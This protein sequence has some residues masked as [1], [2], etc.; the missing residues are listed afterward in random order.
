MI[1]SISGSCVHKEERFVVLEAA[2]IGY[3]VFCSARTLSQLNSDS[4]PI[5]LFTHLQVAEDK[6]DLFGFTELAQ[7]RFF[8]R[9]IS[10]SGVGPRTALAVFDVAPFADILSAIAAGRADL[11]SSAPGVGPKTAQRIILELQRSISQF[12]S[13][14][15]DVSHMQ[16]QL[17]AVEALVS[18]GYKREQARQAVGQ[19]SP[20]F[21]NAQDTVKAALKILT[22]RTIS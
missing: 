16:D 14:Q 10:L 17:D 6:L 12:Q 22:R 21:T 9:L 5:H 11:L 8:E 2:G 20:D 3:K 13:S 1:F 15:S 7:L 4:Q 19:V 18:L